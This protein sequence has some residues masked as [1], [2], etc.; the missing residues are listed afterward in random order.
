LRR[1]PVGEEKSD[2]AIGFAALAI[3]VY[4]ALM[5]GLMLTG[6]TYIV[7]WLFAK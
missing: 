5:A 2:A 7:V 3:G 6:C 4:S 1:I